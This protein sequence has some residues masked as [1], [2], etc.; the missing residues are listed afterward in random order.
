MKS[1]CLIIKHSVCKKA[2]FYYSGLLFDHTN[3]CV[4]IYKYIYTHTL[5]MY[6]LIMLSTQQHIYMYMHVCGFLIIL[7]ITLTDYISQTQIK[8][9]DQDWMCMI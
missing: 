1:Y 3:M 2:I 4:Y 9:G 5:Y 7:K 6:L 8:M